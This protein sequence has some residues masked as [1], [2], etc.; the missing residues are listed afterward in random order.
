MSDQRV[1]LKLKI[2][3][4]LNNIKILTCVD[5][6]HNYVYQISTIYQQ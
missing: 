5:I 3:I 2:Y 1:I 6:L 4:P